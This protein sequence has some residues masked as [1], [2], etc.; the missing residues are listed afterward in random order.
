MIVRP[1]N[2]KDFFSSYLADH[3]RHKSTTLLSIIERYDDIKKLLFT[4][5]DHVDEIHYLSSLK[6]ELRATYFQAIET[7]FEFLFALEPRNGVIDNANLW[8]LL[9]TSRGIKN[10]E[11]IKTI[12]QG[13]VDFLER[14]VTYKDDL[15]M[16]FCQYVFFFGDVAKSYP[17]EVKE[18]CEAIPDLLITLANVF[19]DR[20]EYNAFKHSLRAFPAFGKVGIYKKKDGSDPLFELDVSNSWTY[21]R[22]GEKGAITQ[23]TKPLDYRRDH[24]MTAICGELISN[25]VR[26]RQA[27]FFPG[28]P[29]RIHFLSK[30]QIES[31]SE[32][33]ERWIDF[34]MTMTPIL[35]ETG[36]EGG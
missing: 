29:V 24:Q 8:Y 21:L 19:S 18:S 1:H 2:W 9:S 10:Y 36:G 27:Q 3:Y 20:D 28:D 17:D 22:V 33:E 13:D 35:D 23:H 32:Q 30:D 34:T 4:E 31:A 16:S 11:L 12:G 15:T 25:I 6:A 7:L 14:S 5:A 26:T